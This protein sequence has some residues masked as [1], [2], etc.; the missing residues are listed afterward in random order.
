MKR[1]GNF[2]INIAF[3][4]AAH[5]FIHV[6]HIHDCLSTFPVVNNGC[7]FTLRQVK[8]A[9]KDPAEEDL[10]KI[11]LECVRKTVLCTVDMDI[12]FLK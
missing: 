9:G 6:G 2:T 10:D 3:S 12:F 1:K 8:A 11:E 4:M 7:L 5:L